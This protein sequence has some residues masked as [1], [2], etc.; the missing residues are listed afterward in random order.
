MAM[1]LS[2]LVPNKDVPD[3]VV[4]TFLE[5]VTEDLVFYNTENVGVILPILSA[6]C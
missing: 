1:L 4:N 6:L 5:E 2:G 3:I